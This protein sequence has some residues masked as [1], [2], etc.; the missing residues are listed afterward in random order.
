MITSDKRQSIYQLHQHG[1]SVR[2]I[3]KLMQISR[4]TVKRVIAEKGELR[5]KTETLEDQALNERIAELYK[6]CSGRA[7]RVYE[8]LV[9]SGLE[10][11]YPAVTRRIRLLK[12]A[13]EPKRAERFPDEPGEEMQHDTTVYFVPIG[14]KKVKVVASLLYFRYSKMKYLKCYYAFDRFKMKCFFHEALQYQGYSAKT[15]IIDNTNLARLRGSGSSAIIAEEMVRFSRQYG[16]RFLCHQINHPNRKAGNER[17]FWT[18]E[19]NFLPGRTFTDLEDLNKQAFSWAT[20]INANRPVS[21]TRLIPAAAFEQEKHYLNQVSEYIEPPYRQHERLLDQYGYI[22]FS[23]NFYWVPKLNNRNVTLLEYADKI[24]I[25]DQ[26]QFLIQYPLPLSPLTKNNFYKSEQVIPEHKPNNLK[27]KKPVEEEKQ[28]RAIAPEVEAYLNWRLKQGSLTQRPKFIRQLFQL[29]RQLET[30]V[31]ITII[32]RAQA[33][34]ITDRASLEN[35]A[36]MLLKD[37]GMP[38]M[39]IPTSFDYEDRKSYQAGKVSCAVDLSVYNQTSKA[40]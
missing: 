4:T 2:K 7:Q 15:C 6:K 29:S 21:R 9:D 26:Q 38:R 37:N 10:I 28:L 18:V 36:L 14:E 17:A 22:A 1:H 3:S 35:I 12:L 13:K 24:K 30:T 34:A 31:F 23:A 33:Y 27:R 11:S 19:T 25:Y 5:D 40:I 32:K 8:K 20:Q 39:D 16:F